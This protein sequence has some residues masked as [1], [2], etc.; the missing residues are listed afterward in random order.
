MVT[1]DEALK[2][3][4]Q[5]IFPVKTEIVSLMNAL[6]RILAQDI[7]TDS[8]VPS[9]DKTAVDGYACHFDDIHEVLKVVEVIPAG[10][11]PVHLVNKGECSK[12]MTGAMIPFGADVV[13]MVEDVEEVSPG[14][15]RF[16]GEKTRRNIR[17]Q[18]EDL[19]KGNLLLPKGTFINPL[20]LGVIASS[21]LSEVWVSCKPTAA[22][23]STGDEVIEPGSVLH[24][25]QVRNSNAFQLYGQIT[26]SGGEPFYLGIS[27]DQHDEIKGNIQQAL[28]NYDLVFLTGGVSMGDF[29]LV[30]GVLN[31]LG[32]ETCFNS[33]AVQ[34]GRPTL[35]GKR[36]QKYVF[37]L[38]GNPV[39]A[40][41]QF[42]LLAKPLIRK[43]MGSNLIPNILKL[44]L[45]VDYTRKKASR[46]ALLPVKLIDNS[47]F[48]PL[49]YHGS[50]HLHAYSDAFGI[51]QIPA[52]IEHLKKGDLIDVRQL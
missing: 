1:P 40:F 23:I 32:V 35:F 29:D 48:I 2:I 6:N 24:P 15:V 39:S 16:T 27:N 41:I 30:P 17:Y 8:D 38:P 26:Q 5:E 13:I 12:I 33:I 14:Y 11:K 10:K 21:G 47:G 18:G 43:M 34:P 4:L 37:A 44:Q 25:W 7:Y 36:N 20:N 3:V 50:A 51:I 46:L 22:I 9:A 49:E 31:E 19:K 42:E 52:G 28:E 45:A